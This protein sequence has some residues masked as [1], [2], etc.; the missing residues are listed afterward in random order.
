MF[1]LRARSFA[2][3]AMPGATRLIRAYVHACV[4]TSRVSTDTL[5][6]HNLFAKCEV[7]EDTAHCNE[8]DGQSRYHGS[9][10]SIQSKNTDAFARFWQLWWRVD[11]G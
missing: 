8:S 11:N 5:D 1:G 3:V 9:T 6:I 4:I 7:D 10:M 2:S